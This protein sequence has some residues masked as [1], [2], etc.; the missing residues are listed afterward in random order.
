MFGGATC[1][2]DLLGA[3]DLLTRLRTRRSNRYS[4]PIADSVAIDENAMAVLVNLATFYSAIL[5]AES[6]ELRA[7][8]FEAN[9][10]DYQG[11]TYINQ[12]IADTLKRRQHQDDFWWLNNG[13][14]MLSA[15]TDSRIGSVTVENPQIVNGMQTSSE[16]YKYFAGA[17]AAVE[18]ESRHVLIKIITIPEESAAL[19]DRIIRATNS[20]NKVSDITLRA[21]DKVQRDIEDHFLSKNLYYDRRRNF[22]RNHGKPRK[23]IVTMQFL[24]QSISAVILGQP[25]VS[26]GRPS[27]ITKNDEQYN[28]IFSERR[29]VAFYFA[30][31]DFMRFVDVQLGDTGSDMARSTRQNI[32]FF[33]AFA[34]GQAIIDGRR[35]E[36]ERA[37]VLTERPFK[38]GEFES[39]VAAVREAFALESQS[40]GVTEEVIAKNADGTKLTVAAVMPIFQRYGRDTRTLGDFQRRS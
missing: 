5:R 27:A 14:T 13:I 20:Q 11:S 9:V 18:G 36:E 37:R 33:V 12:E 17:P 4:I 34:S 39:L 8:L 38:A 6:G 40:R 22:Y 31:V 26:R 32:R 21:T 35:S 23:Q 29:G 25:H 2:L 15:K 7:D 3:A 16:I 24:A 30:C 1:E 10:R 19:R 28:Q